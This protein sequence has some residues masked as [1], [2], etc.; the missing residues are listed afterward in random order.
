MKLHQW[1]RLLVGWVLVGI[2]LSAPAMA[3]YTYYYWD[4]VP[5]YGSGGSSDDG[6]G[7][8]PWMIVA[9]LAQYAI[10]G[11]GLDGCTPQQPGGT[12]P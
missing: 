2:L 6:L 5:Y 10:F 9:M 1:K 8:K 11:G 3:Q 4:Y 7:M 12:S